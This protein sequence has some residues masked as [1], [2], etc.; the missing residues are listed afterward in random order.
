MTRLLLPFTLAAAFVLAFAPAN[1]QNIHEVAA[2]GDSAAVSEL[3]ER[4]PDLTESVD[5]NGRTPLHLA[6]LR[7]HDRV[8]A[9]LVARGADLEAIDGRGFT[10]L[11]LAVN[12]GS[13]A[14][15]ESLLNAGVDVNRKHQQYDMNAVEFAFQFECQRRSELTRVLVSQGGELDVNR[16]IRGMVRPLDYAVATR[17]ADMVQ[18]LIELGVDVNAETPYRWPPLGNA[19]QQGSEEVLE[20]LLDAGADLEVPNEMGD[21]PLMLAAERG[22]VDIARSLLDRGADPNSIH[23]RNGRTALHFAALYGHLP[24]V[25][26]LLSFGAAIDSKDSLDLSPLSYAAGYGHRA[27]AELL[28]ENGAVRDP[29]I[30]ENFGPPPFLTRSM[31]DGEAAAWYL[32]HR[33]WAVKTSNHMLVFDAEEFQVTRPTEPS[34]TNGFL[35]PGE[36]GHLNVTAL[37]TA[38]HGAP[39][40][41]SYI[42]E[43][44]DSLS[45][46]IYVQNAGDGWRG[47]DRSVYLSPG[48]DTIVNGMTISTV[49][50]G[51]EMPILAYLVQVDSLVIYYSG[52][53]AQNHDSYRQALHRFAER[54]QRVDLAFW[55]LSDTEEDDEDF[56][57]FLEALN[58]RTLLVLDPDRREHLFSTMGEKAHAWGFEPT[59]FSAENPGDVFLYSAIR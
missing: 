16:L 18:L 34:L 8:V 17:N 24:V 13:R 15:V 4:Q 32:N 56:R 35:T 42:H 45:S 26:Q 33:G 48:Q 19:A 10:V 41:P 44:E 30:D 43:I 39:G 50:I 12:G 46:I 22:H 27:V 21:T 37:Y 53:R 55:P 38:Y 25:R 58:P 11:Q 20:M 57:V 1:A 59:L 3:L 2:A 7:G 14:V 29:N 9:L 31:N 6:A 47:S 54:V 28:L 52:F 40:E 49:G 51:Q 23:E 5:E 36:I